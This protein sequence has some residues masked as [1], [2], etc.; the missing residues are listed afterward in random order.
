MKDLAAAALSY[1]G[2]AE[3]A[4]GLLAR[5]P[6]ASGLVEAAV[7]ASTAAR[8]I[9]AEAA[10]QM[11]GKTESSA[12]YF[13]IR[14]VVTGS[15]GAAWT[16]R[17]EHWQTALS[18]L[19]DWNSR[20]DVALGEAGVADAA[21]ARSVLLAAAALALAV[22]IATTLWITRDLARGLR[23]VME[24]M[25]RM[26]AQDLS[27]P[28]ESNRHDELGQL[29]RSLEQ[30]RRGLHELA[31]SVRE[32]SHGVALASG[33]ITQGSQSL[34]QSTEEAA[35]TL[36]STASATRQLVDMLD[37]TMRT[38][39]SAGSLA[40]E[41]Q[42]VANRGGSVVAQAVST[43]QQIDDASRRIADITALIDGIAFQ[44]NILALNAAVEA[45]RAGEQGRGFAVVAAEVRSLAQRS[46]TAAREIKGLIQASLAKVSDGATQV[47]HA[48]GATEE[49][50][51][52]VQS[53][54]ALLATLSDEARQQRDGVGHANDSI[55]QLDGL[56]QRNAAMAE[57]SAAAAASLL[58]HAHGLAALVD[59]FTL[60]AA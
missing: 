7:G 16:E 9:E 18:A 54:S 52:S 35:C 37:Q 28:V 6:Q 50:M 32:A 47:R 46:A 41:A 34:S 59:R 25:A 1:D 36:Q 23:E 4:L 20:H 19:A 38:A 56:A 24:P 14:M 13:G 31:S 49:I 44:T 2:A 57:Q 27:R 3:R 60:E 10:R 12:V 55:S 11:G 29:A 15:D 51:A 17:L 39:A 43:M 58:Q 5:E 40:Q 48:G 8:A 26:A 45:A 22:G 33:E 21:Q 53:V 42:T 30:T